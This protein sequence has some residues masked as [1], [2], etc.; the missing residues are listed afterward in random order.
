MLEYIEDVHWKPVLENI[1]NNS[2]KVIFSAAVPGQGGIGHINC[3]P[4]IDWI[5]RFH[6]LG[7]VVDLDAT[8]HLL[9]YM[10]QGYHMGWFVN[11]A[12]VLIPCE[13]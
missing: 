9:S 12:M 10:R 11:N 13:I 6:Q 3:R 4:K 1:T 2:D 7:W 8:N 5:K